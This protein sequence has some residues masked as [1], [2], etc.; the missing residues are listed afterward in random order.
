[1][2]IAL[3]ALTAALLPYAV[4]LAVEGPGVTVE[5][6]LDTDRSWDGT[7]YKAYPTGN[8]DI[9]VLKITIPPH[10]ELKWHEHPMPNAAYVISGDL[11]V[12]RPDGVST[13]IGPGD[14]LAEMVDARHRGV[15]GDLPVVLVVFYAGVKGMPLSR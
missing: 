13:H 1:M 9:S 12:E 5:R 8:A 3:L 4:A 2:R 15:T 10:T 7:P 14:V 6:L 11:T